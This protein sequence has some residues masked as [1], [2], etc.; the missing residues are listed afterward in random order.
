MKQSSKP[1]T[2]HEHRIMARN[3]ILVDFIA[4]VY[5]IAG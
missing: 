1:P 2:E 3:P 4:I 5:L